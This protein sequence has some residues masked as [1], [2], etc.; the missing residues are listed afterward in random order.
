MS[1]ITVGVADMAV[2]R[3]V[4]DTLVTYA[5]GSCAGI[6]LF[7]PEAQVA[8]MVHCMLPLSRMDKAKAEANPCMFVDTG[9]MK[10]FE[11]MAQFGARR[12]RLQVRV[13]GCAQVLDDNGQFRIGERNHAALRKILWKNGVL[14]E[15]EDVGGNTSRTMYCDVASGTVKIRSGGQIKEL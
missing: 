4:D 12:D 5:L 10:L 2:S 6:T 15:A 11:E 9:L 8:G 1:T 14:I 7:D 3:D 13:A